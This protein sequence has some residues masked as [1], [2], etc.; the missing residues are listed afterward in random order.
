MVYPTDIDSFDR[1]TSGVDSLDSPDQADLANAQSTAIEA[2]EAKVGIGTSP[3][4]GASAGYVLVADGSGGTTWQE[5][6]GGT[7]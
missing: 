1:P 3:A 4:S 6:D 2:L 7:L 5:L